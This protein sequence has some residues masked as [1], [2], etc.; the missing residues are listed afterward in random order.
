VASARREIDRAIAAGP[1]SV[2]SWLMKGELDLAMERMDAAQMSFERALAIAPDLTGARIGIV[3]SLLGQ[4]KGAEARAAIDALRMELPDHPVIY[5]LDGLLAHQRGE[6]EGARASLRSVLSL[7]PDHSPTQLLL[8]QISYVL[9]DLNEAAGLL[10]KHVNANPWH[11]VSRKLLGAVYLRLNSPERAVA[12]LA[13]AMGEGGG[14]PEYL[15]LLGTAHVR[16]GNIEMGL[17]LHDRATELA[18]RDVRLRTQAAIGRLAGGQRELAFGELEAIVRDTPEYQIAELGL[19]L[20]HLRSGSFER[21][22]KS[23]TDYTSNHPDSAQAWSLLGVVQERQGEPGSARDSFNRAIGLG[24]PGFLARLNLAR[25]ELIEGDLDAARSH[26]EHVLS[27]EPSNA[28]ALVGLAALSFGA[29]EEDKGLGLLEQAR[30]HNKSAVAPRL[31]LGDYY[32]QRGR[33]E[34]ALE[35]AREVERI[36][37]KHEGAAILVARALLGYAPAEAA[38]SEIGEL[39][40]R[41]A[42]SPHLFYL[43]ATAH[44]RLDRLGDAEQ[45][46]QRALE[47]RPDFVLAHTGLGGVAIQKGDEDAALAVAARLMRDYPELPAGHLLRG[48]V[49]LATGDYEGALS[50]N[51]AA[52]E[53][54]PTGTHV[55]KIYAVQTQMGDPAAARR[56]LE[57]WLSDNPDDMQV[58][59]VM[60]WVQSRAGETDAAAENYGRVLKLDPDN[61][62]AQISLA[63][64]Y[65]RQGDPRAVELAEAAYKGQ[66]DDLSLADAFGWILVRN[67]QVERG[68]QLLEQALR[69][70]PD[71]DDRRY[72]R[73]YAFARLGR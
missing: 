59:L 12:V 3:R 4:K 41:F 50:A 38:A 67:G 29:D 15:S 54:A 24:D 58:L 73:A 10:T 26:Y 5:Y 66:S 11:I 55:L 72:R 8:G 21:A 18:P 27:S 37:P 69:G 64:I 25:L 51:E 49:L 46:L 47:L 32:M 2:E 48:E 23:A 31:I 43:L 70:A 57:S 39:A 28:A 30:M 40:E 60:A 22:G 42:T 61:T 34:T 16:S 1:D 6:L 45:A 53:L 14:D 7:Q 13:P 9:G 19:I 52:F 17:E 68:L 65:H 56:T 44:A 33:A 35:V 62:H 63:W 20:A 36:D 71:N